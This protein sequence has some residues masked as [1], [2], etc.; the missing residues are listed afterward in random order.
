MSNRDAW[1]GEGTESYR[2]FIRSLLSI[3]DNL[4]E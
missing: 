3:T 1:L 2:I 4:R